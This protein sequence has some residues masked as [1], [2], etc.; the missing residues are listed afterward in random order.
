MEEYNIIADYYFGEGPLLAYEDLNYNNI[1]L[2]LINNTD[3]FDDIVKELLSRPEFNVDPTVNNNEPLRL[4][5]ERGHTKIVKLLTDSIE[6]Y[7]LH[8]SFMLNNARINDR[9]YII[10]DPIKDIVSFL[11]KHKSKSK[12]SCKKRKMKLVK[13][14]KRKSYRRRNM[15][16]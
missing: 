13:S 7:R 10:G 12:I 3:E 4:A 2:S 8:R 14:K 15:K 9:Q 6:R 11:G 16:K 1:L 5:N